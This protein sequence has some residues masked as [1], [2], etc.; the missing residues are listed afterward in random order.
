[1]SAAPQF[2]VVVCGRA[3]VGK[4]SLLHATDPCARPTNTQTTIGVEYT[5]RT[6]TV[7]D[8]R[9][10]CIQFVD[11]AGQER[12]AAPLNLV[13]RNAHA[14][15]FVYDITDYASYIAMARLLGDALAAAS[16]STF[17]PY[18]IIVGNKVDLAATQRAVSTEEAAEGC[19]ALHYSLLETSA[20]TRENVD[21]MLDT[22]AQALLARQA[23]ASPP[24]VA[25]R[26]QL[27]LSGTQIQ[28][29]A[30]PPPST[31]NC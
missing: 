12:F 25:D 27:R 7:T 3:N 24:P 23:A 26:L 29:P 8:G 17:S 6:I 15:I 30:P 22:L 13:Y 21:E 5:T 19:R 16:T 28:A 18:V 4:T 10:A 2:K 11:T 1:M 9:R 31:C 14:I 20:R